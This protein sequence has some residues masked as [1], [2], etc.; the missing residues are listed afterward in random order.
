LGLH[1]LP[2]EIRVDNELGSRKARMSVSQIRAECRK[3]ALKW[4]DIQR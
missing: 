3:Y 1:G 2:I 4:V